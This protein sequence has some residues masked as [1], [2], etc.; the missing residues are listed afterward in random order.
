VIHKVFDHRREVSYEL[1]LVNKN[2]GLF[3][4]A[5]AKDIQGGSDVLIIFFL[6]VFSVQRIFEIKKN[7]VARLNPIMDK[8]QKGGFAC[9]PHPGNDDSFR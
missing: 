6:E 1:N 5:N 3:A 4:K 9:P 2:K 7:L 8:T